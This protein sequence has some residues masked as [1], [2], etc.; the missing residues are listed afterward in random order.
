MVDVLELEVEVVDVVLVEVEV[1][2]VPFVEEV[3]LVEDELA[4][5]V[6]LISLDGS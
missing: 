2:D 5:E 4:T 3:P 1:V 6:E